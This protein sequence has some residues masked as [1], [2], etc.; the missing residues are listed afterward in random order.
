M[1]I[2]IE[3]DVGPIKWRNPMVLSPEELDS[4]EDIIFGRTKPDESITYQS[5]E[6]SG[7]VLDSALSVYLG[8]EESEHT[9]YRGYH[10]DPNT[11]TYV[12]TG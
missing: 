8:N 10:Y 5:D 2:P 12:K 9:S 1:W 6:D 3:I 7:A 4:A 11:L